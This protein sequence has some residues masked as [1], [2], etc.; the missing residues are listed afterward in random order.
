MFGN[1]S[2]NIVYLNCIFDFDLLADNHSHNLDVNHNFSDHHRDEHNSNFNA[3]DD[4]DE[5]D[6][7]DVRNDKHIPNHFANNVNV[8]YHHGN[9]DGNVD[10]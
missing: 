10:D 6:S 4:R 2:N 3:D 7:N 9:V 8:W 1:Y 5:H